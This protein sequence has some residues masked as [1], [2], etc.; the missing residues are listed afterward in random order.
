MSHYWQYYEPARP[1]EVKNGI[2]AKSKRGC[3]GETWWSKRFVGILESFDL[4]ARLTRG[5]SY[6][7][8]GQVISIDVQPGI[9]RSEVQGTM[10][11]PYA[12]KIELEPLSAAQWDGA[13]K[14]MASKAV[15]AACLLSGEMPQN[16][17]EAFSDAGISL[18]PKKSR[19]LKTDCS[20]PDWSNPCKHIAAVYYLLAEQFDL[21]PFLIF[22]LRGKTKE[23]ILE[24]LREKRA[25]GAVEGQIE[26]IESSGKDAVIP[27][28]DKPG[29]LEE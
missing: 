28:S 6:A 9:V 14:A 11:E 8:K 20:C 18:F 3:I 26:S 29:L 4:G 10:S 24:A 19:D 13:V 16:I 21:D 1:K 15:F 2:K 5:R 7:R 17:E 12:V 23:E 22:K 27:T 25:T